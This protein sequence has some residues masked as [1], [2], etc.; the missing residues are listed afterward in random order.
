MTGPARKPG[1]N[2]KVHAQERADRRYRHWMPQFMQAKG[3][4]RAALAFDYLRSL[5]KD[6]PESRQAATY[7]AIAD[8]LVALADRVTERDVRTAAKFARQATVPNS[9][10]TAARARARA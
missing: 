7:E 10:N 8:E 2:A 3:A 6:L 5:V 4:E 9:L 1:R